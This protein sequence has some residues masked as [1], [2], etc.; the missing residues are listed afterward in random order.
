MLPRV[1]PGVP[2][3]MG[4]EAAATRLGAERRRLFLLSTVLSLAAPVLPYLT[5]TWETAW[6]ALAATDW[7]FA[8]R[9]ALFLAG[10]HAVL[11]LVL[12]PLAY[13]GGYVL[14][15]AFGLSRQSLPAWLVDWLKATLLTM[16]FGML[17]GG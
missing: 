3:C 11:A 6:F 10:M 8:L 4:H 12:L 15:H 5:G 7:P 1:S 17:V 2:E 14:P 9:T 13:Y 16:L